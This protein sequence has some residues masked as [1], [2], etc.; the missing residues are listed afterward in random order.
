MALPRRRQPDYW[1]GFEGG[2]ENTTVICSPLH[3]CWC[4][5]HRL[6]KK[7]H[8]VIALPPQVV[9]IIHQGMEMGDADDVVFGR[10]NSKQKNGA[11]GC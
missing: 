3:G 8:G 5:A 10:S 11:I 1:V 6:G 9:Q 4:A 7:P 2:V